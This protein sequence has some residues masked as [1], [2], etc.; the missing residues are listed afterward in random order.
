MQHLLN[1]ANAYSIAYA[2]WEAANPFDLLTIMDRPDAPVQSPEARAG[3]LI[4][5]WVLAMER[6]LKIGAMAS[7][8]MPYPTLGEVSKRAAGAAFTPS[9]YSDRMRKVVEFLLKLS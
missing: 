5:P 1:A 3:E 7:T 8:V 6:G 9:L 4:A 2:E